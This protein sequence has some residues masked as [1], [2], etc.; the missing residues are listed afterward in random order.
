[1]VASKK[2]EAFADGKSDS[3][4]V[5]KLLDSRFHNTGGVAATTPADL[6]CTESTPLEEL[7]A[8]Q[9]WAECALKKVR[10]AWNL[11]LW[12][13]GKLGRGYRVGWMVF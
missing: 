3:G 6:S 9:A 8:T 4:G 7:Q 10:C 11:S 12:E 13:W 5:G 1:M 2:K